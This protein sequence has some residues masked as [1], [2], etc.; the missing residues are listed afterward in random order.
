MSTSLA[1]GF[2]AP[3]GRPVDSL[4][5]ERWT[6]RWSRLFVPMVIAAAQV[7]PGDRIL[8]VSTGTGEAASVALQATGSSGI[9]AWWSAWT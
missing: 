1:P 4:A 9:P 8:D 7:G 2:H 3:A 6:G 5:Y